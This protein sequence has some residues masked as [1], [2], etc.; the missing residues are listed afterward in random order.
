MYSKQTKGKKTKQ[1][2]TTCLCLLKHKF[3]SY[4]QCNFFSIPRNSNENV[5]VFVNVRT[6]FRLLK[7]SFQKKNHFTIFLVHVN[8]TVDK[9]WKLTDWF[10]YTNGI[11]NN[12]I[13]NYRINSNL[14][15][16]RKEME[17]KKSD[18]VTNW[19]S[20]FLSFHL[21]SFQKCSTT[22]YCKFLDMQM[23]CLFAESTFCSCLTTT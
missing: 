4:L 23:W 11:E 5:A 7:T 10:A 8:W 1:K 13:A 20:F 18:S 12:E 9:V 22:Y 14:P 16:K 17:K 15:F 21:F 6:S 19:F 2:I 3:S